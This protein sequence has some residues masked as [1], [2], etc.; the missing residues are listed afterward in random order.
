[1]SSH[2][3]PGPLE[4][5]LQWLLF[6]PLTALLIACAIAL[7]PQGAQADV[8]PPPPV[9]CT[10]SSKISMC[11][12]AN[13]IATIIAARPTPTRV[14]STPTSRPPTPTRV[15]PTATRV[16]PTST[17]LIASFED[18]D[19]YDYYN[20]PPIR[21]MTPTPDLKAPICTRTSTGIFCT[22]RATLNAQATRTAVAKTPT[23]TVT[24]RR[25]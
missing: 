8:P 11:L 2:P 19:S 16:P 7:W 13:A 3:P 1:M 18:C 6:A 17:P 9:S 21:C 25:K 5:K 4:R 15:P 14:P 24:P 12:S 10:I 23:A 22:N 20:G